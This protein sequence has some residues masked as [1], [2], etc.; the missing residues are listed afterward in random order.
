MTYGRRAPTTL[1][2][3]RGKWISANDFIDKM[4]EEE[5]DNAHRLR[6]MAKLMEDPFTREDEETKDADR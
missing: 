1:P 2:G 3:E 6:G 5:I 4:R